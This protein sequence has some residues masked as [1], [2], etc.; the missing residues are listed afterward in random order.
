MQNEDG[1]GT[2][3]GNGVEYGVFTWNQTTSAFTPVTAAVAT[4]GECGVYDDENFT[5]SFKGTLTKS[6]N[7]LVIAEA[8]DTFA[9]AT[10]V[11]SNSGTLV[12]GFVNEASNGVLLVIHSDGT[13]IFA[14]T[15]SRLPGAA[16]GQERGCYTLS[17]SEITFN[18]ETACKP[19][20][21][22]ARDLNGPY[23]IFGAGMTTTP[24]LPFTIDDANTVTIGGVRYK[25][26]QPN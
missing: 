26:T 6:G 24:A 10:V 22:N 9:T 18:I 25:R 14:E 1:C 23:R 15:Q 5:D 19:D 7:S 2:R 11:E 16:S 17:G 3:D 13:F 21:V 12:G 8:G 20:G 4:N